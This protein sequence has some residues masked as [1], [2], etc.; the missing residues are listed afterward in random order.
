MSKEENDNQIQV[1]DD[2]PDDWYERSILPVKT[3][4]QLTQWPIGTKGSSLL[5]VLVGRQRLTGI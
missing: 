2:E 3:K 5:V 4:I 1:E